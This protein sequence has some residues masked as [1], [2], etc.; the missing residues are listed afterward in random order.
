MDRVAM[1]VTERRTRTRYPIRLEVNFR[2]TRGGQ[3]YSGS[4][5]TLNVSS[6]GLLIASDQP[7]RRGEMLRMCLDW[8]FLLDGTT[9]I[10]LV[11][12][13]CVVRTYQSGFAAALVR[14]QFRTAKRERELASRLKLHSAVMA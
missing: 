7:V 10:Q 14:H 6:S 12:D 8:P 9:P 13:A 5:R 4:G 1:I 11:A 2:D 3:R